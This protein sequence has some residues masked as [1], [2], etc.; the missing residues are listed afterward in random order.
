MPLYLLLTAPLAAAAFSALAGRDQKRLLEYGA[1][2]TAVIELVL[3]L[4]IG[5]DLLQGKDVSASS[6]LHADALGA[7]VILFISVVGLATAIHSVGHLREEMQKGVIGFR[8]VRQYFILFHLFFFA[9]LTAAVSSGPILMWAAVEATTLATAFLITFYNKPSALEA[10]WKFLIINSVGLLLG[11]L[12]SLLFLSAAAGAGAPGTFVTWDVLHGLAASLDPTL[13]MIAFIFVLVG[14]GTKVGLVPMHTWLP[15]AHSNAPIPISSLLSGV[16]LNIALIGVLRFRSV[17]D[18]TID[19]SFSQALLVVFGI[20]SLVVAALIMYVQKNYKRLL[21]YSSIEH[22]GF[23]T[24]GFGLGG[25]ATLPALFHMLYHALVKPV[26]FL[27][28]GNFFLKYNSTKIAEVRGALSVV[29]LSAIIFF[30]ALLAAA[31][32][33]PSGLFFTELAILAE[34]LRDFPYLAGVGL[35]A[36]LIVFASF[37]KHASAMLFSPPPEGMEKGESNNW[38]LISIVL[39]FGLFVLISVYVPE[40][41]MELMEAAT[42]LIG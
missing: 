25:A 18:I 14:F 13:I 1:V 4:S 24:I 7:F 17:T 39:L 32:V 42:A 34:V 22:M 41:L 2:L 9:M 38:T 10:G 40:P 3:A 36:L 15:D 29:P 6:F 23:M 5:A 31:G 37:L 30:A 8:R 20:V 26:L 33:P 16:L 28:A 19:P 12:G 35:V 11:F 21:A 27:S